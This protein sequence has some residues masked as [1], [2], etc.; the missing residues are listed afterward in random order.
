MAFT[1]LILLCCLSVGLAQNTVLPGEILTQLT[2]LTSRVKT[3]ETMKEDRPKVAFSASL[4]L[5][6][7]TH[8]GP[9]ENERTLVFKNIITNFGNHYSQETGIFTAP[10][11]GVYYFRFSGHA[12]ASRTM[13]MTLHKNNERIFSVYDQQQDISGNAS[14]GVTLELVQGDQ[15]YMKLWSGKQ[16]FD[17][18]ENHSTFSGFLVFP[19]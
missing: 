10:V 14:N 11:N 3:L 13:A 1:Q 5:L 12:Q 6:G 18:L 9:F 7:D 4:L 17:D 8:V 16:I 15:V 19:F 2:E